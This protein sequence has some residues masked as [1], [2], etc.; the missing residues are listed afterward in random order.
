MSHYGTSAGTTGSKTVISDTFRRNV[1]ELSF[2]ND[3]FASS[4]PAV[5]LFGQQLGEPSLWG[6]S[7][8]SH[9]DLI[10]LH[11][12]PRESSD[13]LSNSPYLNNGYFSNGSFSIPLNQD[14]IYDLNDAMLPSSLNDLFTPTELHARRL[15]QQE[16]TVSLTSNDWKV[17][18]L[19]KND[20]MS[21]EDKMKN[22][23]TSAINIPGGNT[24]HESMINN[25]N[26]LQDDP[27]SLQHDDEVQFFM[28]D[29]EVIP[30]DHMNIDMTTTQA[31][32]N[33]IV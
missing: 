7:P 15:R 24:N 31:F 27:I 20:Y 22:S 19:T 5:S 10:G 30:N 4:A 9:R 3:P 29:D 6:Q 28:E 2:I 25:S 33:Q 16:D 21:Y 8:R 26:Y 11:S 12:S 23:T 17:P 13:L 14:H 1:G 18:F 32:R